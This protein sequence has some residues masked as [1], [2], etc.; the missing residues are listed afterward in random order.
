MLLIL[1]EGKKPFL[2]GCISI[3]TVTHYPKIMGLNPSILPRESKTVFNVTSSSSRHIGTTLN[4]LSQDRVFQ[5][6]RWHREWLKTFLKIANSGRAE[7]QHPTHHPKI[8][9]LNPFACDG[10]KMVEHL[11]HWPKIK[12]FNHAAD[13]GRDKNSFWRLQTAIVQWYNIW[14]IIP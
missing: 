8:K 14:L 13:T 12:S 4:S 7:V 2:K 10:C 1:G 3:N 9:C 5:S 11:T 6:C